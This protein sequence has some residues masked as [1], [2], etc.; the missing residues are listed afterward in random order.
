MLRSKCTIGALLALSTLLFLILPLTSANAT[1]TPTISNVFLTFHGSKP[2]P[3]PQPPAGKTTDL[4]MPSGAQLYIY[5]YATGGAFPSWG[6]KNG[7]Y[8]SATNQAGNLAASLA[9]TAD[10]T[11]SF[12][13]VTGMQ[14]TGGASISDYSSYTSSYRSNSAYGAPQVSDTFTVQSSGNL[15]VVF[16]LGGLQ[17]CMTL[18]GIPGLRIDAPTPQSVGGTNATHPGII[19]AHA[20]LDTG[21][22]TITENT[23]CS[24][25]IA[26]NNTPDWQADLIA[27]FVFSS[28]N[29]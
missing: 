25:S 9:V 10:Y 16:A 7:Q 26:N 21:F 22:Y 14:N 12:Q 17:E 23:R 15:V 24:Q 19:I 3:L 28:A 6:F 29:T 4:N 11:N 20:Y 13:T 5:G 2:S 27:V 18:T 1:Q 8:A